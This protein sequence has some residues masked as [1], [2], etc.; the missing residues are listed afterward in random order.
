MPRLSISL[1]HRHLRP[2]A[3]KPSIWPGLVL[4]LTL[5]TLGAGCA[6][7]GPTPEAIRSQAALPLQATSLQPAPYVSEPYPLPPP[8]NA[9][10][11]KPWMEEHLRRFD[12]RYAQAAADINAVFEQSVA[13]MK[14]AVTPA[15]LKPLTAGIAKVGTDLTALSGRVESIVGSLQSRIRELERTL[16]EAKATATPAA[17]AGPPTIAPGSDGDSREFTEALKALQATP[18]Q[19]LPLRAWVEAH[20]ADPRAP[21]ALFQLGLA[22]LDSGYPTAGKLYLRRL[23]AEHGASGQAREAK[24]LLGSTPT[25]KKKS[26]VLPRPEAPSNRA[27]P[28]VQKP[29][30]GPAAVCA[31]GPAARVPTAGK[32]DAPAAAPPTAPMPA[33]T[34]PAKEA[35][36]KTAAGSVLAP[37]TTQ[38]ATAISTGL[39]P[40]SAASPPAPETAPR[41]MPPAM[42]L[43]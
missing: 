25:P 37:E 28:H 12:H 32:P 13:T 23:V 31:P 2:P 27:M 21:E 40:R 34:P 39:V 17:A 19:T 42:R 20:P 22:F 36:E 24:A 4:L 10:V 30:C 6:T 18:R 29:D 38:A 15:D 43:K 3:D 33:P 1:L 9:E 5:P 41:I 35:K 26:P 7:K 14:S 16:N 8:D 11:T